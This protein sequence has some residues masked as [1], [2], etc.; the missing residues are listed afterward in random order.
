MENYYTDEK[1]AQIILSLLKEYGIKK[2]VASPGT[3]NIPILGSVQ[4]DNFFE[5]YSAPDEKSAAYMACGLSQESNEPVVLSCTGA[6]ASRNYLSGLTEAYYKKLPIIA[7]TSINGTLNTGHL[8]AQNIDRSSIQNDVANY[9]VTIPIIRDKEDEWFTEVE[10]NKALSE[11][12]RHGGGPVHINLNTS[13]LGTFHTKELPNIRKIERISFR[14]EVPLI[15]HDTKVLVFVGSRS[16]VTSESSDEFDKFGD[17]HNVVFIGDH[18]SG[19]LGK[20]GI[21]SSSLTTANTTSKHQAFAELAPDLILH[22]GEVSG[23]YSGIEYISQLSAPVWR[24]SPDGEM[25]DTFKRLYKIFEM[26]EKEFFLAQNISKEVIEINE[27]FT[28]W[29]KRQSLLKSLVPEFPYSNT[30]IAQN[31]SSLIPKYSIVHLGI[32]NSLRNWNF[33]DFDPSI[34][35]FSNVGGFGIDGIISTAVGSALASKSKLN[36]VV[37]GDLAF[38]YDMN[39]L[40]NR[41]FPSNLRILLVNNGAGTEFKNST[42]IGARFNDSEENI[43]A[44]V[45]HY[46]NHFDNQEQSPAEAWAKSLGF[47]YLSAVTKDEFTEQSTNFLCEQSSVP[48]ILECITTAS[49]ESDALEL[50]NNLD[51]NLL[52]KD[53]LKKSVKNRLSSETKD[54]LKILIKKH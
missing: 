51:N 6:T 34:K 5:V 30:W 35:T 42:H 54:K 22:I 2:I 8:K 33:V 48:I 15:K 11:T 21:K 49:N 44:A 18:T 40:G 27:Y 10:I 47:K 26:E 4:Y 52:L 45:N 24:I 12:T 41:H 19:N 36:F 17:S 32:L 38:F 13:Y 28:K 29:S 53:R 23:D 14:E 9:S 7:I 20:Y 25:R 46:V 3:T 50:I 16:G 1:N 37:V 31:I 43:I 39:V